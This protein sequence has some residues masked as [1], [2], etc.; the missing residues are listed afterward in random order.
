M[1]PKLTQFDILALDGDDTGLRD[2]IRRTPAGEI[3]TS[4]FLPDMVAAKGLVDILEILSTVTDYRYETLLLPTSEGVAD[5]GGEGFLCVV[6]WAYEKGIVPTHD[7]LKKAAANGHSNVVEYTL[8]I[9]PGLLHNKKIIAEA[10][11]SAL[12]GGHN[13]IARKITTYLN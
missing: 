11:R 9:L 12:L 6:E 10:V 4:T 8:E 3:K 7:I 1:M 5:A 13:E 2:L